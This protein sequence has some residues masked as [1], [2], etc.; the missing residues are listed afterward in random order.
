MPNEENIPKNSQ[1]QVTEIQQTNEN[2]NNA[3]DLNKSVNDSISLLS[4]VEITQN[5]GTGSSIWDTVASATKT[6]ED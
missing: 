2:V 6:K 1:Q 3:V 5:L 4:T